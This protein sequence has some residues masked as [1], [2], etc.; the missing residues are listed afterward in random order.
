MDI[1]NVIETLG[2]PIAVAGVLGYACWYLIKF[3]TVRLTT[4]LTEAFERHEK[5]MIKLID[6][7]RI[8]NDTMI[9]HN[10]ET[11]T[12]LD[13]LITIVTKLL[14]GIKDNGYRSDNRIN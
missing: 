14:N 6:Q 5:I 7:S 3:I 13:T 9:K 8:S 10:T 1:I 11:Y 2:V 4:F 12:K